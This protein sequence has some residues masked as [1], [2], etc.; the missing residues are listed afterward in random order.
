MNTG[1][2][3]EFWVVDE[4]GR[5]CDADNLVHV[6]KQAEPEFV[7]PMLEVKTEPHES[8]LAL[9]R[10]LQAVLETVLEAADSVGKHLVPLGTPLTACSAAA[11]DERGELFEIIYG[12]GIQSSKNCAG[13]H[14]HFEKGNV[15]RQLNLLTAL[16]PALALVSSSPYYLGEREAA[17]SRAAAYRTACGDEFKQFC[18]LMTY[19]GSVAEWRARVEDR[20]DAFRSLAGET[21]V[22]ADR[23]EEQFSPEDTV[24][25]PVRLRQ[26][27]PTVEWRAPDAALPSQVVRLATD[28]GDLVAKTADKPLRLG[29]VGVHGDRIDV[30]EF[31]VLTQ[32]SNRAIERGLDDGQVRA[33]LDRL[34]FDPSTYRP[35]SG[36][37]R[38]PDSLCESEARQVR[39]MFA[40]R[41]RSDVTEL[42]DRPVKPLAGG[43]FVHG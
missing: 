25:N 39:L 23:V 41:L 1:I 30:P 19:T 36:Q 3:M 28:V 21:G 33:Y 31:D 5:L 13:T 43:S 10:D 22:S 20:F 14:V 38:G 18:D 32:V 34:G 4:K 6:H 9:R 37:L 35:I 27:Q 42:T 15:V 29:G 7:G 2:E 40:E 12:D 26:S 11:R 17:C 8:E 16:D 24:L